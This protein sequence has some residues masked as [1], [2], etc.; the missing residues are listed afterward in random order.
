[1][2][3]TGTRHRRFGV[4]G[5]ANQKHLSFKMAGATQKHGIEWCKKINQHGKLNFTLAV[6]AVYAK[7][8]L[9]RSPVTGRY[10]AV[11]MI[12]IAVLAS[13]PAGMTLAYA[14]PQNPIA[15]SAITRG[16]F[17]PMLGGATDVA[18]ATINGGTYAVITAS[19]DNSFLIINVS[20]PYSPSRTASITDGTGDF[21]LLKE[22]FGVATV[23]IGDFQYA[24]ITSR[25]GGES[26]RSGGSVTIA[27]ISDP[28]KPTVASSI[29]DDRN[30]IL[31][32]A[33]YVDIIEIDN[34]PYALITAYNENGFQIINIADPTNPLKIAAITDTVS[35]A[36][37]DTVSGATLHT[38]NGIS[39]AYIKGTPYALITSTNQD[40]LN[41]FNISNPAA[42]VLAKSMQNTTLLNSTW[43]VDTYKVGGKTYAITGS[44]GFS[45]FDISDPAAPAIIASVRNDTEMFGTLSVTREV[46]ITEVDGTFYALIASKRGDS[47]QIADVT[48]P[49]APSFVSSITGGKGG[50]WNLDGATGI[51]IAEIDGD[52]YALITAKNGGSLQIARL[53][54]GPQDGIPDIGSLP[55]V[56]PAPVKAYQM[57]SETFKNDARVFDEEFVL[58]LRHD[59]PRNSV[60]L[61]APGTYNLESHHI[62]LKNVKGITIRPEIPGSEVI[63]SSSSK[64]GK[65]IQIWNHV[66]NN[67]LIEGLTLRAGNGNST[68]NNAMIMT[69]GNRG[70]NENIFI[71]NNTFEGSSSHAIKLGTSNYT[72]DGSV[73]DDMHRTTNVNIYL[74]EFIDIGASLESGW[75][76]ITRNAIHLFNIDGAKIYGNTFRNVTGSAVLLDHVKDADIYGNTADNILSFAS[77][78]LQYEADISIYGNEATGPFQATGPSQALRSFADA[79]APPDKRQWATGL[80]SYSQTKAVA[81]WAAGGVSVYENYFRGFETG[82]FIH[83]L[84]H[85]T[86]PEEKKNAY[87]DPTRTKALLYKNTFAKGKNYTLVNL[88]PDYRLPAPLNHLGYSTIP[89]G[90]DL[91]LDGDFTYSPW[92]KDGGQ[93]MVEP[94]IELLRFPDPITDRTPTPNENPDRDT[95]REQPV[96][97][98][99]RIGGGGGGGGSGGG[100]G[101]GGSGGGGSGTGG[102]TLYSVSWNC[103]TET[104]QVVTSRG[105][106][107]VAM[108]GDHGRTAFSED[109]TQNLDGRS[110]FK[111]SAYEKVISL[112]INSVDGRDALSISETIRTNSCTGE[113]VFS[114]YGETTPVRI[115]GDGPVTA[116]KFAQFV[117]PSVDPNQYV[118]RYVNEEKYREWF[119]STYPEFESIC[120]AIGLESGCVEAYEASLDPDPVAKSD[121]LP[122]PVTTPLPEVVTPP[123]PPDTVPPPVATPLPEC[124]E[125]TTMQDGECVLAETE[126]STGGCLIA[127][128]AYG[129]ELA[130]QVQELREIR[131]RHLMQTQSGAGFMS[132]FNTVY[133]SFSPAVA[134]LQR[135]SPEFREAVKIAITPMLSTLSIMNLADDEASTISLGIG[136]IALNLGMYVALPTFAGFAVCRHTRRAART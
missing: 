120:D 35:G 49:S 107:S 93:N 15:A 126:R 47:V 14:T 81:V 108:F 111:A 21:T 116:P 86:V 103:D 114:R 41:I 26:S 28:E 44:D 130:P 37:T 92:Y 94:N 51:A 32:G 4:H 97:R 131:D 67:I 65:V 95:P 53:T 128:A 16:D 88:V 61:L 122:P 9:M 79:S 54:G 96:V 74:N 59:L 3:S 50:F 121:L 12:M 5:H 100:G 33:R 90:T 23:S 132:A 60:L 135:Q 125:G 11:A 87:E 43:G 19:S 2:T 117:D 75:P 129:S 71:R 72:L 104:T 38:A 62:N 113:K 106:H 83:Y 78:G 55:Q 133:Y 29:T 17:Y 89:S 85:P 40:A 70:G 18:V 134:D 45:I 64:D 13:V 31:S 73:P 82:F 91:I 123:P 63:L 98:S 109:N 52:K 36:I 10:S 119:H 57:T 118:S 30:T 22:A 8:T 56:V 99:P 1:M 112:R 136:V 102:L 105:T 76:N 124:G 84:P 39:T 115:S 80:P 24:V 58:Q 6:K 66:P 110:A 7:K 25:D 48:N 69:D 20:N 77:I 27:N 46:A 34:V 127:T 68:G 42:P 101:G